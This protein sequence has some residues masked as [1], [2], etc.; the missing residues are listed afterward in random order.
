MDRLAL[1]NLTRRPPKS[2]KKAFMESRVTDCNHEG[3]T[4][5]FSYSFHIKLIVIY[6]CAVP[7]YCLI[8]WLSSF[9]SN[10]VIGLR[11]HH[12]LKSL[13]LYLILQNYLS[14]KLQFLVRL[15]SF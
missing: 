5:A 14:T 15:W 1:F 3:C 11:Y 6:P 4:Y 12:L 7:T 13:T 2:P 9:E 10:L 8:L